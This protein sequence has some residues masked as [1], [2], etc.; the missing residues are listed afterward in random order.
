MVPQGA[1][2][3]GKED[4][5]LVSDPLL[6]VCKTPTADAASSPGI[7]RNNFRMQLERTMQT[8][9][10][11]ITEAKIRAT[12]LL[13]QLRN[14][15]SIEAAQ[16]FKVLPGLESGT[17]EAILGIRDHIRH[18]HA[19]DVTAIEFGYTDWIAMRAAIDAATPG[20]NTERLFQSRSAFLNLWV[21]TYEEARALLTEGRFLFPHREHFVVCEGEL[22]E[23]HGIDSKDPDWALIGFDWARPADIAA[24]SRL[25]ERLRAAFAAAAAP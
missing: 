9:R 8:V 24:H 4:L 15:A 20:F 7:E 21:R 18:K 6:A 19:L 17:P 22:L 23:S 25:T 10:D 3:P 1:P 16:R 14:E 13:K 11:P 2:L 12:R 5:T